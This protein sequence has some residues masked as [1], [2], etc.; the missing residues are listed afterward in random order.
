MKKQ[1]VLL[2]KLGSPDS[3]AVSDVRKY[4]REFLMDERV[5]DAPFPIR[6]GERIAQ[7]VIAPVAQAQLVAVASL[8]TTDRGSGGYGSTGR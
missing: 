2:V 7:M 3:P 6:R 5:L 4:L 1:G 8:S